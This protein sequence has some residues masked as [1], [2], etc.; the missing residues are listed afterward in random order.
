MIKMERKRTEKSKKAI[1][2]LEI[3]KSKTVP[4]IPQK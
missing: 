3:E 4:I 1:A 2:S